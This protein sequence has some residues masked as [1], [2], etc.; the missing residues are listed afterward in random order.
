MYRDPDVERL[1]ADA[2]PAEPDFWELSPAEARA[3]SDDMVGS[4]LAPLPVYEV[5]EA[6]VPSA[7]GPVRVRCYRP[8]EAPAP[9]VVFFHGGGWEVGSLDVSDRPLR[10]LV[11]DSGCAV[12]SVDY[13]LA[14]EHPYPAGLDDCYAVT[15][16]VAGH[17]ADVGGDGRFLAVAGDSAGGN[18]AAAVCQRARDTG[19]PR[20]DHQLL[21]YP[22]V[23]PDFDTASYRDFGEGH[24]LTRATMRSF[25]ELYTGPGPAPRYAD[26]YAAGEV[27]RLPAATVF[28]CGLDVLSD[29]GA[30]YARRLGAAGV[31]VTHVHVAGL[32]HGIWYMD[33]IGDR[34]YQFGLDIAGALRRAV[35]GAPF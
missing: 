12:V 1:L 35:A 28:T 27:S 5:T 2:D 14:P 31:A 29:E 6:E 17:A 10:R 21:V 33:A 18:L 23:T 20:I 34:A 11:R 15:E 26:L 25:W 22:V 8:G 30:E 4:M 13:R 3:R 32:I 16:W 7:A 24:F 19:G 9:V